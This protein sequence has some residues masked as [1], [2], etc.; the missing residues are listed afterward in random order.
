MTCSVSQ[1]DHWV[2]TPY[3]RL[4][5]RRWRPERGIG[6]PPVVLFH[7]SLGCVALWRDFPERL[8]ERTGR[9]VIAYDRLGFGLSESHP[10]DLSAHFIRDEAERFFPLLRAGL[11]I[12][13]FVV[14][15]HSVGGAMAAACAARYSEACQALITESAQAF[16]E[17]RTLHGI[18]LAEATFRE[19]GQ[20]E[21][22]EKYHGSKARWVLAAWTETWLSRAFATWTIERYAP[23]LACPLLVIHGEE[24]EYGSALHPER[25]ARL[26]TGCSERLILPGC[27]HV[28]HREQAE[29]VLAAV[30][31]FLVTRQSDCPDRN[32]DSTVSC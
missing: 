25:I 31:R 13:R 26:A 22:L 1:E 15:G 27:H 5:A 30:A 9:D 14:F 29:A 4:F 20:I 6:E 23:A 28:P 3:G 2:E 19:P 11:D 18:R 32:Q 21:R 24:D 7:D 10:G 16:V 17:K 12:T 8:A